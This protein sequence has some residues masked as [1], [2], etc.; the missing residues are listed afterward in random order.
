M[1]RRNMPENWVPAV[2]AWS[3]DLGDSSTL[4]IAYYGV[5]RH[6]GDTRE[7]EATFAM[8]RH[9]PDVPEHIERGR[10]NDLAGF[11]NE[12]VVCYWRDPST[13]ARFTEESAFARWLAD[14]ARLSGDVGVW[15]EAFRI[16][17]TAR[18]RQLR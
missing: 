14:D 15:V 4:V 1:P 18:V 17:Y 12:L 3:A 2:P 13:Y 6:T 11:L 16:L 9:G 5:Q 8:L 7:S 10:F